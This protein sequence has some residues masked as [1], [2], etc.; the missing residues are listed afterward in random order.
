MEV[1]NILSS[2]LVVHE[3]KNQDC[4][5]AKKAIKKTKLVLNYF[6]NQLFLTKF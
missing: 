2:I 4:F 3:R 5:A 1:K 6:C